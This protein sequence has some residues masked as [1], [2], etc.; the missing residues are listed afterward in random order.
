MGV[1]DG[2]KRLWLDVAIHENRD[3][4]VKVAVVWAVAGMRF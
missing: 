4:D 1:K 3:V 2:L